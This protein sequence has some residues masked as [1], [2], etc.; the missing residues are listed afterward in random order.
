MTQRFPTTNVRNDLENAFDW[1]AHVIGRWFEIDLRALA[2]FRISLGLLLIADLA[3][4]ARN[5]GAFYTDAGVLPRE[6]LFSDY[7]N[8][9]SIHALSGE[10]WAQSVLF[11]LAGAFA[12]ALVVGYRTRIATIV[13]WLLLVSLHIRNPM[14]LNS[15]DVLLRM[16]LFWAIFL[17]LDERWS[18]SAGASDTDRKT[19]ASIATM[20]LLLQVVFMYVT[21]TVHKFRG[22]MWMNGEALVYILSAD[23]F[24]ILL[25]NVIADYHT[26]LELFNYL[27]IALILISPL[28]FVLPGRARTILPTLFVGMHL[29]MLVSMR[30]GLFPLIVTAALLPFYPPLVWDAVS[31]LAART[32]ISNAIQTYRDQAGSLFPDASLPTVSLHSINT[33]DFSVIVTGGR[34]MFF[35]VVPYFMLALVIMSNAQALDYAEVPDPGDQVLETTQADQSWRM[36]APDPARTTRW[37]SAA[38]EYENGSEI[39]VLHGSKVDFERPDNVEDTYDTARWRKYLSNVYSAGNENHRSYLA[40]YLCDRWNENHRTD[41]E[42]VAIFQMYERVDPY[43]G[44]TEAEGRVTVIDYDCSGEFVQ[45]T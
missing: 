12:L 4:R 5:L 18:I 42:S 23:Q 25:G 32:G 29:G 6:A 2:A 37:F 44:E 33:P 22:D 43:A 19:T 45:S 34:T 1:I 39:D 20:A 41:V 21:N 11:C 15:G 28:M 17:P 16:L 31:D 8:V 30:I 10:A 26:L 27:W 36:F 9:Y 35:T 3:L 13:S 7:T 24:T 38:G 40:N 14:V